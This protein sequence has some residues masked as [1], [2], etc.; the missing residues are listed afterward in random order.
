MK[1][2]FYCLAFKVNKK[3]IL[4]LVNIMHKTH[5]FW[6]EKFSRLSRNGRLIWNRLSTVGSGLKNHIGYGNVTLR[7]FLIC[8][9][10]KSIILRSLYWL[11]HSNRCSLL[12]KAWSAESVDS[13]TCLLANLIRNVSF[14]TTHI[15]VMLRC[16]LI[17]KLNSTL[18][19][20]H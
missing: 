7:C 4:F 12:A 9:K 15:F 16:F 8:N 19:C 3:N 6:P 17:C 2:I 20:K 10:L 13:R 14:Q 1:V 18:I 5:L 11:I